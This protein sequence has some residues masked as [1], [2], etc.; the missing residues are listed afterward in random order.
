V[1]RYHA[2]KYQKDIEKEIKRMQELVE[3]HKTA[4]YATDFNTFSP[5]KE[6]SNDFEEA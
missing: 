5:I 4:I 3:I 6:P 2:C 1:N